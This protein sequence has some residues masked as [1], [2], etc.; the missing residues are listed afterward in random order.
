LLAKKNIQI[1]LS[2]S[3]IVWIL[4]A[5]NAYFNFPQHDD[6]YNNAWINEIGSVKTWQMYLNHHDG[7]WL[8]NAIIILFIKH[9]VIL[10][11]YFFSFIITQILALFFMY[12]ILKNILFKTSIHTRYILV[13]TIIIHIIYMLLTPETST[14]YYWF[15][16][17]ISY[18]TATLTLLLYTSMLYRFVFHPN[19]KKLFLA[20][21][22]LS[23]CLPGLH[24]LAWATAAGLGIVLIGFTIIQKRLNY[25][26]VVIVSILIVAGVLNIYLTSVT[27]QATSEYI[28]KSNIYKIGHTIYQYTEF[29]LIL[30]RQPLLWCCVIASS[31]FGMYYNKQNTISSKQALLFIMALQAIIIGVIA[32]P[33]IFGIGVPYRVFNILSF[34]WIGIVCIISFHTKAFTVY[35][36]ITSRLFVHVIVIL[37]VI[38]NTNFLNAIQS[39]PTGYLYHNFYN[40]RI[41]IIKAEKAKQHKKVYLNTYEVAMKHYLAASPKYIKAIVEKKIGTKPLT[42]FYDDD[43]A[44]PTRIGTFAQYFGIDSIVVN[45]TLCKPRFGLTEDR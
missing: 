31:M 37:A 42:Q 30:L 7:R 4:F 44:I 14:A 3:V 13:A 28:G 27:G 41:A 21:T 24:E 45:D 6:F 15:T 23:I 22:I 39:I 20:L 26:Y 17:V 10:D 36:N 11:H 2:I 29:L 5:I 33:H 25:K 19:N 38:A 8:A 32:I 12:A 43:L 40:K 35:K 16:T 34:F 1:L 9:K 18:H